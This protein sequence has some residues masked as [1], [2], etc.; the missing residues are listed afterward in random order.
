MSYEIY[1]DRAFIK[2]GDLYVPLVNQGSN[3]C[4]TTSWSGRD[5]PEMGWQVLNWKRRSK[6]LFTEAEVRDI[7]KDYEE[8]SQSSG[9]CFKSRNRSFKDGEFERWILCGLKSARTIEAYISYGNSLYILDYSSTD[10]HNWP[11]YSFNTTDSFLELMASLEDSPELSIKFS[12]SRQVYRPRR[13]RNKGAGLAD[14][15]EYFVLKNG[16]AD[17]AMYFC[18]L[19][20]YGF[21]YTPYHTSGSVR[22]FK[23]EKDAVRYI[24][25]YK[26]LI[27]L[28]GSDFVP[29]KIIRDAA[30]VA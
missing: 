4:W 5:I 30:Q 1:Y 2:V 27:R 26:G 17:S 10:I 15:A 25:K 24:E 12:D 9:T 14:L 6:L 7:A 22:K 16:D 23:T 11:T 19:T 29:E 20:K 21:R 28:R 8:I 18:K 3:N 13:E